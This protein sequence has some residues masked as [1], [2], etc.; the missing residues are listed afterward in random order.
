VARA[1]Y[2]AYF[3]TSPPRL[4]DL[5]CGKAGWP[6]Y[7]L[8]IF[9]LA[10]FLFDDLFAQLAFAQ[11]SANVV[12]HESR[13]VAYLKSVLRESF[14]ISLVG[15]VPSATRMPSGFALRQWLFFLIAAFAVSQGAFSRSFAR[16][17]TVVYFLCFL[18]VSIAR[19]V[20]HAHLLIDVIVSV[21]FGTLLFM[22]IATI[23]A[24]L[25]HQNNT[26]ELIDFLLSYSL[27]SLPMYLI[28][29][30]NPTFW[31]IVTAILC[32]SIGCLYLKTESTEAP[33]GYDPSQ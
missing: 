18:Y 14:E 13:L 17:T 33:R 1:S 10:Q 30:N 20:F 21:M 22:L 8:I 28:V 16:A 7:V 29:S 12:S 32:L 26:L 4:L 31:L 3:A 9:V 19:M 15:V 23:L 2:F 11:Q 25:S 27:I 24:Q 6:V 5:I